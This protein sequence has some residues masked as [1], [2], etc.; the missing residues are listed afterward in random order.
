MQFRSFKAN[1]PGKPEAE[2]LM[3]T[4]PS[5]TP[6]EQVS[7]AHRGPEHE[8]PAAFDRGLWNTRVGFILA[9][10]GSAVG[11]GNMWRF[12]YYTA[13]HG[14][15]AFVALYIGLTFLLGIPLLLAEFSVGRTTRLSPVGALRKVGGSAWVP[16]GYVYVL[17]GFLILAFYSVIA[18]WVVRY[19]LA[20]L[21]TGFPADPE[22]YFNAISTGPNAI[23]FHLLFMMAV[24][25]IVMGGVEK[26]IERASLIMMPTLF[27]LV[28]GLAIWA[29]TLPGSGAGYAFY[30][31]PDWS[32][33]FNMETFGAAT[34]QAAFSL[35][36]GMGAMLTFASYLSR[37][38]SL[39]R[40]GTVI[41]FSDFAVAFTAGLLVFPVIFALGLEGAVGDSTVGALF[42]ALPG[43][44]A[45]M[46]DT[47]GRIV[48][49]VFFLALLIGAVT[50][51]ISLLEVVTSS[52]IDEFGWGRKKAAVVTGLVIT[53]AGAWPALDLNALDAYDQLTGKV[54]LPLGA[55]GLAVLVGWVM[56]NP[57]EE[58]TIGSGPGARRLFGAWLVMLRFVAP[59]LLAVVLWEN[60][61]AAVEAIG[62]L[63][64]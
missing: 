8:E 16:M 43:G 42:I 13:E 32:A 22:A 37:N 33:I 21:F 17:A 23:G 49:T 51:A 1:P 26:G 44:F 54:F 30:L 38:E 45:T 27:V 48:G 41:A 34:S 4:P 14:G 64:R 31:S 7:P 6:P 52:M 57:L 10:V 11:L 20:F 3:T 50:S 5:S 46:G 39:P 61:P 28:G 56:K 19:S 62:N 15:A 35:S 36:L 53:A 59:I 29:T 40:E 60:V 12:P 2:Q 63:F 18:G 9:A 47:L 24:I 25:G 55:L 58:I